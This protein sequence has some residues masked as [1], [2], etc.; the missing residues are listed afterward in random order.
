MASVGTIYT[1]RK[2]VSATALKL[3]VCVAAVFGL[4][5]LVWVER[6][7]DNLAHVGLQG[8]AQFLLSAVLNTDFLVQLVL[9]ALVVAGVSLLRDLARTSSTPATLAY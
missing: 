7:F 6:V 1:A 2:L 4:G 8:A 9:L 5:A 3:Y